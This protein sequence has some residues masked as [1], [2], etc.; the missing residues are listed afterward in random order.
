LINFHNSDGKS[1]EYLVSMSGPEKGNT[2]E[3]PDWKSAKIALGL[4]VIA[5]GIDFLGHGIHK[6]FGGK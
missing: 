6:L 1:L 2:K 3:N 4:G 5:L